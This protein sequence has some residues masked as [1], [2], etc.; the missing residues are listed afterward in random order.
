[1]ASSLRQADLVYASEVS[2][3]SLGRSPKAR[4]SF[5]LHSVIT[6][7]I[8]RASDECMMGYL[9]SCR[10]CNRREMLGIV[11]K[12]ARPSTMSTQT[13]DPISTALS[14]YSTC[15]ISDALLKLGVPTGGFL[16]GLSIWSPH[17]QEGPTRVA[18]PAY[19]VKFVKNH[20][21]NAPVLAEHYVSFTDLQQ[22]RG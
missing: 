11:T 22:G 10:V 8:E 1:V 15:D 20:Q 19:T 21:T 7:S 2:V 16:P 13:Q 14:T 6:S 9:R 18:G 3:H 5:Y 4:P 17:R 12:P